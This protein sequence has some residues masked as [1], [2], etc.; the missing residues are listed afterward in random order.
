M[1]FAACF[2]ARKTERTFVRRVFI[3]DSGGMSE[4]CLFEPTMPA[5]ANMMSRRPYF[6]RAS[7]TTAFRAGESL[8]SNWRAWISVLG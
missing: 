8:A 2:I 7:S 6:K 4:N 1:A 5:F 3:K